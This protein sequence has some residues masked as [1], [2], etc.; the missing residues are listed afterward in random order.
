MGN[1]VDL[2]RALGSGHQVGP[3]RMSPSGRLELSAGV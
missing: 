2:V 1:V 3:N